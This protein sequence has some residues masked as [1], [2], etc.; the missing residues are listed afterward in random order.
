MPCGMSK[1]SNRKTTIVSMLVFVLGVGET[2]EHR[3]L[4][5]ALA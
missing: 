2:D 3:G 1:N 5:S 4:V